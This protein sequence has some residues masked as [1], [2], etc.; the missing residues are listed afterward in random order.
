MRSRI[1]AVCVFFAAVLTG[2]S[3]TPPQKS[4]PVDVTLVVLLPDGQP[5]KGLNLLALP[6]SANQNQ[7]GGRTDAKGQVA[8]KLNPGKYTFAI[9]GAPA[10]LQAVPKKYQQNDLANEF[11]VP[12]S[13][14]ATIELKLA[15]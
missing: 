2:C 3:S 1:A 4:E 6:T 10:A 7:G 5:G 12:K 9:E 11:E 15:N 8:A 14:P 13:G